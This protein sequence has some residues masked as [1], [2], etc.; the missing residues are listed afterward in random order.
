[1]ATPVIVSYDGTTNDDDAL[2]LGR[3]LT[4]GGARLSLAYVRHSREYDPQREE[5]GVYDADRRLEQGAVWLGEPEIERH[6]V[7]DPSTSAGLAELAASKGAGL[8]LFG[9]DYRTPPGRVDP[10]G[11]AQGL[12]EGSAVAIGVAAAGLRTRADERIQ[13]I[14]VAGSSNG[15]AHQ[16]AAA[17]A[18]ALGARV[19]DGGGNADLIVVDS[20]SNSPEGKI[21]LGGSTRAQLDSARGSVIVLPRGAALSF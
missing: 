4:A 5:I 6:V 18:Q 21:S 17:L 8:I 13:T 2:A 3:M 1:M 14:S 16:T 7:I 20:Q 19:L 12:L 9:S 10:G 15:A 11:S